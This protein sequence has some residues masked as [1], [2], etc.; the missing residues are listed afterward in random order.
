MSATEDQT[1]TLQARS[2]RRSCSRESQAKISVNDDGNSGY[3][4]YIFSFGWYAE[5][6]SGKIRY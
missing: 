3:V 5:G 1:A 4:P 2:T 6:D